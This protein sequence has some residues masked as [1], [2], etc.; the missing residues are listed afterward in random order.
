LQNLRLDLPE[1]AA[2]AALKFQDFR[3]AIRVHPSRSAGSVVEKI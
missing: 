3:D 2:P 1:Y